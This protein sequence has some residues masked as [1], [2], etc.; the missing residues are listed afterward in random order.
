[1][2]N[3][4]PKQMMALEIKNRTGELMNDLRFSSSVSLW[5][6]LWKFCKHF[7]FNMLLRYVYYFEN[8]KYHRIFK[9]K[10]HSDVGSRKRGLGA[11]TL[12][13]KI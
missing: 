10:F 7:R 12:V 13:A 11:V 9:I 8:Y 5:Q 6:S 1:M 3:A 4:E 2:V